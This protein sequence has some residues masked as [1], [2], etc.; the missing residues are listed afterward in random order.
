MLRPILPVLEYVVD[1][2]YIA[3]FLCINQD[4]PELECEGKCYLMQMLE[5]QNRE[6]G[7]NLPRIAMEEYPIGFVV[8]HYLASVVVTDVEQIENNSYSNFYKLLPSL[9]FFRPPDSFA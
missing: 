3:E 9:S 6:K 1:Q 4:R 7:E 8:L 2:D 5:E